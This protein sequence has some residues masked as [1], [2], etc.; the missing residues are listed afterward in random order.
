MEIGFMLSILIFLKVFLNTAGF[1]AITL[2]L[3]KQTNKRFKVTL[4][5]NREF[6]KK[7]LVTVALISAP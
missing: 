4:G 2:Q 3:L 5:V 6:M 7:A 1:I